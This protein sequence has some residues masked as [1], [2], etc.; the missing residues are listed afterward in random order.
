MLYAL[1]FPLL[2]SVTVSNAGATIA[3]DPPVKLSLNS[4]GY[5]RPGD[6]AKLRIRTAND[7]YLVVLRATTEGRIRILF[8][9][10]PGSDNFVRGGKTYEVKGR[11]GRETFSVDD[12]DGSGTVYAAVSTDPFRFD[13]FIRGDHWDYRAFGD[14]PV[15][16]DAESAFGDIL[17]K[18]SGG[19]RYQY[20][21]LTY[22]VGAAN[23]SYGS[24]YSYPRRYGSYDPYFDGCFG[25]RPYYGSRFSFTLSFG[26]PRYRRLFYPGY[27]D[28][29]YDPFYDP[30]FYD[31]FYTPFY[32]RP[33]VAGYPY[34][35]VCYY[36]PGC[37]SGYGQRYAGIG[38]GYSFKPN[39][40]VIGVGYR[41]RGT[42]SGVG[43]SGASG[44]AMAPRPRGLSSDPTRMTGGTSRP[45]PRTQPNGSVDQSRPAPAP[46][47]TTGR[48]VSDNP[49]GLAPVGS[50]TDAA[51]RPADRPSNSPAVRPAPRERPSD[52]QGGEAPR[53]EPARHDPPP[54]D[55]PP[56][57]E[58]PRREAPPQSAPAYRP[59]SSSRPSSGSPSQGGGVRRRVGR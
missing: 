35:N 14:Y 17:E 4:D 36:G 24:D 26:Y 44:G 11:G 19:S 42:V 30:F 34:F 47:P 5:F 54:S 53:A 9:L 15:S 1:L 59:P 23:Y 22:H 27:Y 13:D 8:P 32:Y 55:P 10:D 41:P 45:A 28:A 21:L 48:R 38:R 57:A 25:C 49:P 43:L 16:G 29:F 3:V 58:P 18:M 20:D 56:R 50:G 51:P 46:A 7:G 12:R 31:P 37:Y 2:T 40:P 6:N 52:Q 39:V 33:V